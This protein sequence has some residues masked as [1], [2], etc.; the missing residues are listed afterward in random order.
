MC[1]YTL[2]KPTRHGRSRPTV[3]LDCPSSDVFP[4]NAAG[5]KKLAPE[6][7]LCSDIR[8]RRWNRP[9][10]SISLH[11]TINV[12]QHG[13]TATINRIYS[14]KLKKSMIYAYAHDCQTPDAAKILKKHI[15]IYIFIE[16]HTHTCIRVTHNSRS[17]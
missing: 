3:A 4:D 8:T 2:W 9:S 16:L 17:H 11:I 14:M 12:Y 6:P 15:Y 13:H 10:P 5:S 7:P 1:F